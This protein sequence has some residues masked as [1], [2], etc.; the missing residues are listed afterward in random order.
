LDARQRCRKM[1]Y[2]TKDGNPTNWVLLPIWKMVGPWLHEICTC[3]EPQSLQGWFIEGG[4]ICFNPILDIES[5]DYVCY[6]T[7][8]QQLTLEEYLEKK[9]QSNEVFK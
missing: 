2:T 5:W 6:F 9:V 4:D 1:G 7:N 3:C 8:G